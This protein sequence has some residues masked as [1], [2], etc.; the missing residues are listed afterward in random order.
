M[1]KRQALG[2]GL[3]AYFPNMDKESEGAAVPAVVNPFIEPKDPVNSILFIPVVNIRPNP[4]QP[5]KE[6]DELR[7]QELSDSI[8]QHGL[9]QPITV[10]HLGNQRFEL[11]SGERRLRAT[12]MTGSDTIPAYVREAS[13]NDSIAL[14][15]IEN[16]QREDL[17]AIEVALGYQRLIEECE[18][19]QDEVSKKVGKSRSTVTNLLRLLNLPAFI[20]AA[21]K[22]GKISTGHARSLLS[23]SDERV[24]ERLMHKAIEEDY[25][26]RQIE[27]AVRRITESD[28]PIKP[29]I[30]TK[31]DEYEIHLD[32]I[33]KRLR[34]RLSTKVEVKK[35]HEGG[36]IRIEYYSEDDL[37][38]LLQL[39]ESISNS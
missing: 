38:R 28:K 14:A 21:L 36:E 13:D 18:L 23:I 32:A 34:S 30:N 27:E 22:Q 35:K 37:E 9:I 16:V 33:S 11:I 25:S 26:V 7:L 3:G 15:L 20:Q 29:K 31:K 1:S 17:N 12:K 4:N 5:R 19:T 8:A 10:R 39:F 2:R 24:Q 6:F